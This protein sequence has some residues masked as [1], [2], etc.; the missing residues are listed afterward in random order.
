M[1]INVRVERV[2]TAVVVVPTGEVDMTRAD[3]LRDTLADVISEHPAL[4]VV[5]LTEVT[6]MDV[7]G[8]GPIFEA[9]E[10]VAQAGGRLRVAHAA[11]I[12]AKVIDAV[13]PAGIA[14]TD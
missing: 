10:K 14:D 4:V 5:D 13:G 7:A 9:H 12:L 6:F 8:L 3:E 11:P 2:A 1:T